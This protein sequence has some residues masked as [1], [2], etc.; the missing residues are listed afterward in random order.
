MK[1]L[2]YALQAAVAAGSLALGACSTLQVSTDY[3]PNA[4]ASICHT[5]MFA[6]EHVV[7]AN[8]AQGTFGN[9]INPARLRAAIQANMAAKGIQEVSDR[10]AADC[11]VGYAMGSAVIADP[12]WGPGLGW[13]GGWG[14]G[15][16]GYNYGAG[17]YGYPYVEGVISVDLFDARTRTPIWHAAASQTVSDMTGPNAEA[18]ISAATAAIFAKF[19]VTTPGAAA[20]PAGAPP[21]PPAPAAA[22]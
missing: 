1:S 7:S 14:W 20:A 18:K 19:P 3:N 22:T 4:S 17:Y 21:P 12:Y 8:Q 2:R 10:R 9:P 5:Y 16:Y 13:G 11:V 6:Q 15:P